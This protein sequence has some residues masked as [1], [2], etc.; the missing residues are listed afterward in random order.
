MTYSINRFTILIFHHLHY[1]TFS[2]SWHL[3]SQLYLS[4]ISHIGHFC[5]FLINNGLVLTINNFSI[6]S[7]FHTYCKIRIPQMIQLNA[8]ISFLSFGTSLSRLS[9]CKHFRTSI[10][11]LI[12]QHSTIRTYVV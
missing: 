8:Y 2:S 7:F 11:Q 12:P 4:G 10:F 6:L 5:A 9:Q 1:S 3:Q